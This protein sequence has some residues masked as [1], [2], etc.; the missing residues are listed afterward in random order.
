[1][2]GIITEIA[3]KSGIV[4]IY[5]QGTPS[6]LGYERE[7]ISEP[8]PG[9]VRIRQEAIGLNFVDTYYRDGKF[10]VRSFP[11]T[12]GVEAAGVIEAVGP[13]VTEFKVGDRVG[14]HFITGAYAESRVVSTQQLIHIP[15]GVSAEEA[16]AIMVKGFT[17]RMLV[18]VVRPISPGD[19]VLVHAAAGG[20]GT[21]VTK[22]A[23]ALGATVIGTTGSEEKKEVILANGADYAFLAECSNFYHS[24]LDIT[25][26]KGVDV[27]FDGVGR[28]TFTH[29]LDLIRRG[30]TIVLYG[31]SSGQPEHIDHA[32][33]RAKSIIM[34]TPTLSAYIPDREALETYAADTFKALQEGIFGQLAITRYP[35][36][37]AGQAQADLEAR[38]TVGSVILV[39]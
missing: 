30:G 37:Q 29:S 4:K 24:I 28:D 18:K 5:K 7:N 19:I 35:L 12:P 9:E 25:G 10:P 31:S 11:Y 14:Y 36:S 32:V 27:V 20:V 6:V 26:G 15:D 17:A 34:A 8:G 21:L 13:W 38:K 22:W 16:S 1:M 2:S 23:K 39:P 33:L 3:K